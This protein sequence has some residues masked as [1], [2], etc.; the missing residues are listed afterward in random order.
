MSFSLNLN[1][2]SPIQRVFTQWSEEADIEL[3]VKRD[4]LIDPIISGNKWRK[5]S[6]ILREHPNF[7]RV[8]TYGGPYSNHL[9][10]TAKAAKLMGVT[11]IGMIRGEEPAAKS[12]VLQ[13][14]ES[15]GMQ[16]KF[17]SRQHYSEEKRSSG[18]IQET[19]YISEGGAGSLGTVGCLAIIDEQEAH[20]LLMDHYVVACGT[21][22]TLA[23]MLQSKGAKRG[24]KIWGVAAVRDDSLTEQFHAM[25]DQRELQILDEFHFGGFA[26]TTPELINFCHLFAEETGILLDPIY[27]AKAG[28]AL[29]RL[30]KRG[31]FASGEKICLVHTGGM[32]GW[33][34]KWTESI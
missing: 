32:T 8:V 27:T 10:A 5:L 25:E 4:D 19:L 31:E 2:P 12:T 14:C 28:F 13:L 30:C 26:R 34:G 3:Y 16:L 1:I 9:I 24:A 17:L 22:T 7:K 33:Y 6:G 23:G 20:G 29:R 11:C 18:L 15:F 21:G